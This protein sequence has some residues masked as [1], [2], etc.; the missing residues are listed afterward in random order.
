MNP[1]VHIKCPIRYQ[2]LIDQT[3]IM[4]VINASFDLLELSTDLEITIAFVSN[5][6]IRQLNKAFLMNDKV[7]DV[8]AFPTQE[9][10]PLT[11][12]P[13]LGDIVIAVPKVKQQAEKNHLLL[14]EEIIIL[15]VHGLLHLLGH[16]HDNANSKEKMWLIQNSILTSL[17]NPI[18]N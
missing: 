7:T 1:I 16:D 12:I 11:H 18:P 17:N 4:E 15:I 2:A 5:A 8:L 3:R 6:K 13:Y 9:A 14:M 10:D